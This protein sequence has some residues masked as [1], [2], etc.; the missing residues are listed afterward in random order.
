MKTPK[1]LRIKKVHLDS[2][3]QLLVDL[4]DKGIDYVD[5][6]GVMDDTQDMVGLSFCREYMSEGKRDDFD[7]VPIN[8]TKKVNDEIQIRFSDDDDLNQL[9]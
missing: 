3:I 1:E 9:I 7:N 6:I 5:I 2:F 4:Y 8:I